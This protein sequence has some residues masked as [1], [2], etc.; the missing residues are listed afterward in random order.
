MHVNEK[1]VTRVPNPFASI[2]SR[3]ISSVE[4][5]PRKMKHTANV[6]TAMIATIAVMFFIKPPE[7]KAGWKF[8]V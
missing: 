3:A 7:E 5:D 4:I 8:Q 1:I 6:N 2:P